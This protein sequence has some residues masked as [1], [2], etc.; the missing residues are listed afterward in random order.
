MKALLTLSFLFFLSTSSMASIVSYS[1]EG[2]RDGVVCKYEQPLESFP[3][4][5]YVVV[6]NKDGS[7]R[8]FPLKDHSVLERK[9][10]YFLKF[11][12]AVGHGNPGNCREMPI[13]V[14]D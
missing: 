12:R 2:V 3:L 6:D 1:V 4:S 5:V 9:G 11:I 10:V 13:S 8:H 14:T 7:K